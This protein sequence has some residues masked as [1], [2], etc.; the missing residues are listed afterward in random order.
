MLHIC[1]IKTR[2]CS[3]QGTLEQAGELSEHGD[4][5]EEEE[6][7]ESGGESE[8]EYPSETTV[9][10]CHLIGL[11]HLGFPEIGLPL[12]H[13]LYQKDFPLKTIYFGT[14]P[15]LWKSPYI[16]RLKD[17]YFAYSSPFHQNCG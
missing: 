15:H 5:S 9:T 2:P 10:G 17:F 1:S 6:D 16:N 14:P 4:S 8:D 13:P 7:A 3:S 12:N 11:I